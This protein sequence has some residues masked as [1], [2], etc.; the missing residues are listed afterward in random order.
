[1]AAHRTRT[2]TQP[3]APSTHQD[4]ETP[5]V[6]VFS[7]TYLIIQYFCNKISAPATFIEKTPSNL[8]KFSLCLKIAICKHKNSKLFLNQ[9]TRTMLGKHCMMIPPRHY[10]NSVFFLLF[11]K[12]N[13]YSKLQ[14]NVTTIFH[15]FSRKD[16]MLHC[17]KKHPQFVIKILTTYN[18]LSK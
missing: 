11:L 8:I 6:C 10:F 4:P 14:S 13:F 18:Q 5:N 3:L 9:R 16:S 7:P 1:M 2:L 15:H 17:R 12:V